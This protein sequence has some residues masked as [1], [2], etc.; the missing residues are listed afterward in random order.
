MPATD[1]AM[2]MFATRAELTL[3]VVAFMPTAV[4][5]AEPDSMFMDR[6]PVVPRFCKA[7]AVWR[8]DCSM[9]FIERVA[10]VPR[11]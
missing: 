9:D 8:D 7:V 3:A 4:R 11:F 6:W 2:P 5:C 1:P 10:L